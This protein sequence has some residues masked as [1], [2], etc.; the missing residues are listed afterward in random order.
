MNVVRKKR[1]GKTYLYLKYTL[2]GCQ[3]TIYCGAEGD[4]ATKA[5]LDAKKAEANLALARH[6]EEIARCH[7]DAAKTD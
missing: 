5:R 3:R 6:Y 4:P 7:R 2:D 1:G